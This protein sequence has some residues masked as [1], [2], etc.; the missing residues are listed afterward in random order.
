MFKQLLKL[1]FWLPLIFPLYLVKVE[2]SGIPT[3][4]VELAIG[5]LF[6]VFLTQGLAEFYAGGRKQGWRAELMN[7]LKNNR[8]VWW[9]GLVFLLIVVPSVLIAPSSVVLTDGNTVFE[10]R[11]V[12]LGIAK[13]WLL[14]PALYYLML[15]KLTTK[16]G[17]LKTAL[18]CFIVSALP[19]VAWAFYQYFSGDFLTM[20]G[21]ASGPFIN[22]NYLAMYL[23]PAVVALWIQL[24]RLVLNN[25]KFSNFFLIACGAFIYSIA[26]LLTQS[27][28]AILGVIGSM[29]I[30]LM[31]NWNLF[32][33]NG[34]EKEL[35]RLKYIVYLLLILAAIVVSAA[36][37]LFVNTEKWRVLLELAERS[38][39]SVRLQIYQIS[40]ALIAQ[41]PWL[42]IGLG[43][44]EAVYNLQAANILGKAPYEWVMI[45]PHNI[46][47]A[48][49]LN[50]G[51]GGLLMFLII[52]VSA[53]AGYIRTIDFKD[54][55][56]KLI[57]VT[58]LILILIH[59]QIDTHF[60]KNDLALMFWLIIA[61]VSLPSNIASKLHNKNKLTKTH[62]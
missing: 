38:S 33:R 45:H 41:N 57:G 20:D 30:Y 60:F 3:N 46:F 40:A 9:A 19:L 27:Y 15:Y 56:F 25:F 21:R 61:L 28:G 17:Q 22:A 29:V 12:A 2:I 49:W 13:G 58:M 14:I 1:V 32:K 39:S 16:K 42:G 37:L 7:F 18:N 48:F 36:L 53:F 54:K 55:Y 44:Y 31:L 5:F 8:H 51:L 52:I 59:G 50:L 43:Q 26:L 4:L 62:D 47:L 24:V 23:S 34:R 6:A 35:I 10:G 11:R